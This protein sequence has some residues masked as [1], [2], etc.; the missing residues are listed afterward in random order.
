M[1]GLPHLEL[2]YT[3]NTEGDSN[4][5]LPPRFRKAAS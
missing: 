1:A 3:Q 5:C 2:P 4:Y